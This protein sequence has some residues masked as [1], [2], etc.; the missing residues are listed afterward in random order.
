MRYD[1]SQVDIIQV[2]GHSGIK[3]SGMILALAHRGGGGGPEGGG[4]SLVT[5]PPLFRHTGGYFR[6]SLFWRYVLESVHCA[7]PGVPISPGLSG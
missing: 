7:D 6:P 5:L 3:W 1:F 4:V 2:M